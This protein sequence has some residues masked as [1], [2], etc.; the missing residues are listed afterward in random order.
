MKLRIKIK[1]IVVDDSVDSAAR[2]EET[3]R[4]LDQ[5]QDL[6]TPDIDDVFDAAKD[7]FNNDFEG[8]SMSDIVNVYLV[9]MIEPLYTYDADWEDG[10][11][12][13]ASTHFWLDGISLIN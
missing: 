5:N 7:V 4:I 1:C 8:V 3:E 2:R 9:K 10:P 13:Y 12:E 6:L 11:D